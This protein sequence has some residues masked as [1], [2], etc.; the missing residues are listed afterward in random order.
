MLMFIAVVVTMLGGQVLHIL[1][2]RSPQRRTPLRVRTLGLLWVVAGGGFWILVDGLLY[3]VPGSIALTPE[4]AAAPGLVHWE[5]AWTDITLGLLLMG[6]IA[7]RN[8]GSWLDA[9]VLAPVLLYGSNAIGN[10]IQIFGRQSYTSVHVWSLPV[11]IIQAGLAVIYLGIYRRAH[12]RRQERMGGR[13][14]DSMSV[15]RN[16][17]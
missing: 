2:D 6:C 11:E 16:V 3:L 9:A 1:L 5:L 13:A 17:G 10:L 7:V 12:T 15:R 4:A 8:R 14:A